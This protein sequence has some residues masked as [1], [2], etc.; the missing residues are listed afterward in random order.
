MTKWRMSTPSRLKITFSLRSYPSF[1]EPADSAKCNTVTSLPTDVMSL[2][3]DR[4]SDE[5]TKQ[6]CHY[7][8]WA[9]AYIDDANG[10]EC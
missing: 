3:D 7:I 4:R 10:P 9:C 1:D 5:V 2:Q 6:C 8:F